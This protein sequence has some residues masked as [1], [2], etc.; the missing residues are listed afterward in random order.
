[1]RVVHRWAR[2]AVDHQSVKGGARAA[3]GTKAT[4]VVVSALG[5]ALLSDLPPATVPLAPLALA[6]MAAPTVSSDALGRVIDAAAATTQ[7][8]PSAWPDDD[9]V[10]RMQ[11]VGPELGA[12]RVERMVFDACA[13]P[14]G[15]RLLANTVRLFDQLHPTAKR[16]LPTGLVALH[17]RCLELMPVD[18]Q[19]PPPD[20][21]IVESPV[22]APPVDNV[23]TRGRRTQ[24]LPYPPR[25]RWLDG[26][27]LDPG[28]RLVLPRTPVDLVHWGQLLHNCLGSFGTAAATSRSVIVGIEHDGELSYCVEIEPASRTIRQFLGR[29]NTQVPPRIADPVC[30]AL[31]AAG[32]MDET[33]VW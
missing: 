8:S 17:D 30:E 25:I 13:H 6:V 24:A 12:A 27:L 9:D 7:P 4:R 14:D 22:L 5:R 3:F 1:V 16:R 33:R 28:L 26:H 15:V 29:F 19:P 18:P 21:V 23:P 31:Y 11:R 2:P 10:A 20:P 32:V